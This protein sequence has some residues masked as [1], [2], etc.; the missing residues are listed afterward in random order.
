MNCSIYSG[1][2]TKDPT[3]RYSGDLC[4]ANFTIAVQ[5]EFKNKETGKYDADFFAC[6]AFGNPAKFVEKYVSKGTKVEVRGSTHNDD[7]TDNNGEK[8]RR[9]VLHVDNIGF[10][11]S[12]NAS[13]ASGGSTPAQPQAQA[14]A[15]QSAGFVDVPDGASDLDELPFV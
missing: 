15:A 13:Q 2:L 8:H 10:A 5:R 3:I 7:W 12:K 1:R 11:E 14:Q 4:I 6:T 9:D